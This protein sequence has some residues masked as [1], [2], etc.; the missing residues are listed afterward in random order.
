MK[1]RT[2]KESGAVWW[3]V[4]TSPYEGSQVTD[5]LVRG[6]KRASREKALEIMTRC[7]EVEA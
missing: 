6:L 4:E 1:N 5:A 7:G 3:S 2:L